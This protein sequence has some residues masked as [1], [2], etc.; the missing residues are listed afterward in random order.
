MFVC[1]CDNCTNRFDP[2]LFFRNEEGRG[3]DFM[4]MNE[5]A[6]DG[7]SKSGGFLSRMRAQAAARAAQ[8]VEPPPA[9]TATTDL[10]AATTVTAAHEPPPAPSL[11][12]PPPPLVSAQAGVSVPATEAVAA[13]VHEP[14]P[15]PSLEQPPPPLIPVQAGV[16]VLAMEVVAAAAR[17]PPPEPS[18]VQ[19]PPPFV[20]AQAPVAVPAMVTPI[21]STTLLELGSDLSEIEP[22]GVSEM[23]RNSKK[24]SSAPKGKRKVT[25]Q[26]SEGGPSK[27]K[28]GRKKAGNNA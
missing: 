14:P 27:R 13:A 7:T 8:I 6:P 10:E 20:L 16:S 1:G 26:G 9:T 12:Q 17:E 5:S 18:L 19:T 21:D 28:S 11:E 22:E 23:P 3:G 24:K 25:G 2:R 4:A 15:A